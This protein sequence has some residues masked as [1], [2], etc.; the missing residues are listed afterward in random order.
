[1]FLQL[2]EA[3]DDVVDDEDQEHD[4]VADDLDEDEDTDDL[5]DIVIYID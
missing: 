1:M 5:A 2:E 3:N 4:V